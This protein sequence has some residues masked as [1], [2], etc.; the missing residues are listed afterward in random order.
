MAAKSAASTLAQM[1]EPV[2]PTAV[3]G[4]A[5]AAPEE[6]YTYM[7]M[8]DAN[9]PG[10]QQYLYSTTGKNTAAEFEQAANQLAAVNKLPEGFA[11]VDQDSMA[12]AFHAA[13]APV[14]GAVQ[15]IDRGIVPTAQEP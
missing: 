10:K 13:V 3:G 9:A 7:N 12:S 6:R 4:S 8:T 5:Q 11:L 2:G 15:D 14:R 1:I